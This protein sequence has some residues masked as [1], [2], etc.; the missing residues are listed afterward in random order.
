MECGR[1]VDLG[2]WKPEVFGSVEAEPADEEVHLVFAALGA[3]V[4]DDAIDDE[5]ATI[6]RCNFKR[7]QGVLIG[8][9]VWAKAVGIEGEELAGREVFAVVRVVVGGFDDEGTT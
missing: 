7:L 2:E 4:I 6:A 1:L 9:G 3:G 5:L 8:G